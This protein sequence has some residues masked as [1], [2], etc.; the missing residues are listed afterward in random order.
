MI[1]GNVMLFIDYIQNE[2]KGKL[3]KQM[4]SIYLTIQPRACHQRA[5][6][7]EKRQPLYS[8]ETQMVRRR[9]IPVQIG[10][11][12]AAALRPWMIV[13]ESL[14][15]LTVNVRTCCTQVQNE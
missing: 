8:L 11:H 5:S 2:R 7:I 10:L 14:L 9:W 6:K 1:T 4:T 12:E 13:P 15:V 3:K